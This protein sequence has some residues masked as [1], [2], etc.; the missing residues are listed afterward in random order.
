MDQLITT[1]KS[2]Q[3]QAELGRHRIL[4]RAATQDFR[5]QATPNGRMAERRFPTG[6]IPRGRLEALSALRQ[7]A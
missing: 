2:A 6:A 7:G 4:T 1:D 3:Q 5:D